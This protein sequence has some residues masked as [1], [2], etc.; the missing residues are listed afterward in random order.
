MPG[1]ILRLLPRPPFQ[2]TGNAHAVGS[3]L[4]MAATVPLDAREH[5][6][7]DVPGDAH[8][9]LVAGA[10]FGGDGD[11]QQMC[12]GRRQLPSHLVSLFLLHRA[13]FAGCRGGLGSDR[14]PLGGRG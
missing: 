11:Q 8:D 13:G 12:G 14:L 2:C 10:R 7:R 3:I 4:G 6:A 9:H 1:F 5:G